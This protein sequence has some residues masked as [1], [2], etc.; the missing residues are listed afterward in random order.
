MRL[1]VAWEQG[2]G[3][4]HIA[5]FAPVVRG[6]LGRGHDVIVAARDAERTSPRVPG[7]RVSALPVT[8][9]PAESPV[10]RPAS[11]ADILHNVGW[12]SAAELE[13]LTAGWLELM[14]DVK[15]DVMVM[16]FSPTALLAS[17]ARPSRRV[18]L[19]TGFTS[20]PDVSPLPSLLPEKDAARAAESAAREEAILDRVNGVLEAHGANPLEHLFQLFRRVDHDVLATYPELDHYGARRGVTYSGVW[21]DTLGERVKWPAGRGP[22]VFAYLKAFPALDALLHMLGRSGLPVLAYLSDVSAETRRRAA[23]PSVRIVDT[24]VDLEWAARRSELAILN[25]GHGASAAMLLAG[26]PMLEIPLALEQFHVARRVAELGA[27]QVAA[28]ESPD[29]IA[30]GLQRLLT[31]PRF[32]R[33]AAAFRERH[34]T[35]DATKR[36]GQVLDLI[37]AR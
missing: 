15:P 1:L 37:V 16:D 10:A 4:G 11:L 31:D 28:P 2:G 34:R 32:E 9:R 26:T 36:V 22:R 12:H 29:Q 14:D 17:Q 5:R 8:G 21:A 3:W 20:P 18:L 35:L 19:S 25:A 13:R 33:N 24:P 27:G 7:A 23:G 30:Q 6:L